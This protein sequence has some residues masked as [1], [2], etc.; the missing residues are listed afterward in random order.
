MVEN[1][2][3]AVMARPKMA[4]AE[5]DV[6]GLNNA[7]PSEGAVVDL[8][9]IEVGSVQSPPTSCVEAG[10]Q[11]EP[12]L[13]EISAAEAFAILDKGKK[14]FFTAKD[15]ETCCNEA[16]CRAFG[17][18]NVYFRVSAYMNRAFTKADPGSITLEDFEPEWN[19]KPGSAFRTLVYKHKQNAES[20]ST[21]PRRNSD[22]HS[23]V[24]PVSAYRAVQADDDALSRRRSAPTPR[25]VRNP[26]LFD[27][28]EPETTQEDVPE[29]SKPT[30]T[31]LGSIEFKSR[32]GRKEGVV[33]EDGVRIVGA[34]GKT[35]QHVTEWVRMA[36]FCELF[37]TEEELQAQGKGTGGWSVEDA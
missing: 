24:A 12:K 30:P 4:L 25:R 6:L 18:N 13:D 2:T 20:S 16:S 7:S 35:Y 23:A 17:A 29:V 32:Q 31:K 3:K 22:S 14:G 21:L 34:G 27:V 11:E 19:G 28:E 9:P 37:P 1:S 36:P 15:V 33:H 10:G 5:L 8:G 26:F